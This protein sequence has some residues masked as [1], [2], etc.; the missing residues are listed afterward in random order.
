[1]IKRPAQFNASITAALIFF[2]ISAAAEP[3]VLTDEFDAFLITKDTR[4]GEVI[5]QIAP[6]FENELTP[7]WSLVKPVPGGD[8]RHYLREGQNDATGIVAIDPATGEVSLKKQPDLNP[9][10]YY[11]EVRATNDD[12]FME[13]VLIIIARP[14]TPKA[15]NYLDIF[16]QRKSASGL[17]FYATA[18][19]DPTKVEYASKIASA[20]LVKDRKNGGP[21]TA[22]VEKAGA[23]MVIFKNFEERNTAVE[24]WMHAGDF[25]GQDLQDEEIIPDYF[26]LGG[27]VDMR[28]DASIE[29]ITHLIHGGGII[30]AYPQLQKRLEKATMAAIEDK[31]FRPWDGLPEDSFSHEFLTIGLEIYYGGRQEHTTMGRTTDE[32]GNAIQPAFR[33]S[34]ENSIPLTAENLEKKLPELFEIVEFL[35]P[36]KADF[37]DA[38][39]WSM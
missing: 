17:G 38:M 16:T 29:E 22:H 10:D 3:P 30:P 27:P 8:R 5:G 19:V 28:R 23:S 4:V 36:S 9:A 39:G 20:L 12:G 14:E 35:F 33:L 18:G 11:A 26:R 21:V 31:L 2:T 6:V 37:W 24:F 13:Q 7:L 1:M 15:E 34:I 25:V 32:K